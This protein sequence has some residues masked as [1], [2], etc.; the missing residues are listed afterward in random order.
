MSQRQKSTEACVGFE[1]VQGTVKKEWIVN[2]VTRDIRSCDSSVGEELAMIT[3]RLSIGPADVVSLEMVST[4][5][6]HTPKH[7]GLY[8]TTILDCQM[9]TNSDADGTGGVPG[10]PDFPSCWTG[11]EGGG[12][13]PMSTSCKQRRKKNKGSTAKKTQRRYRKKLRM[14]ANKKLLTALPCTGNSTGRQMKR[15]RQEQRRAKIVSTHNM[16]LRRKLRRDM[17]NIRQG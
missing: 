6:A 5:A 17:G 16:A 9:A 10:F 8:D 11:Q 14:Q 3:S 1:I 13:L 7:S 15:T 4:S 2:E 12:R